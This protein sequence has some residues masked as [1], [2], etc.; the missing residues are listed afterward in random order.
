[1]PTRHRSGPPKPENIEDFSRKAHEYVEH[2]SDPSA[3]RFTLRYI[4]YLQS[5]AH[6]IMTTEPAGESGVSMLDCRLIRSVLRNLYK[7]SLSKDRRAA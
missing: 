3:K 1:M 5:K 2:I 4:E 7:E 6:G